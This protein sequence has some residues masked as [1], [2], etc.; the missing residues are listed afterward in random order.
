[1][2]LDDFIAFQDCIEGLLPLGVEPLAACGDEGGDGAP[3]RFRLDDDGMSADDS[4]ALEAGD[5]VGHCRA[6]EAD[7]VGYLLRGCPSVAKK[8]RQDLEVENIQIGGHG[9]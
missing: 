8:M 6:G 4:V 7:A 5:A 2:C 1:M 9:D 3:H